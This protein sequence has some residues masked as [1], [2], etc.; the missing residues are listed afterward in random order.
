MGVGQTKKKPTGLRVP[1]RAWMENMRVSSVQP[2]DEPV[3]KGDG[4]LNPDPSYIEVSEAKPEAALD[5]AKLGLPVFPCKGK[6]PLVEYGFKAA[7]TDPETISGWWKKWPNANIGMPTG[8]VSGIVGLDVDVKN[9][10][11]GD[12]ELSKLQKQYGALPDTPQVLTP[13]GGM[14]F[15]FQYPGT[16]VKSTSGELGKGIDIRGDGGYLIVPP[17]TIKQQAY[18]WEASSP[19]FPSSMPDWLVSLTR[20]PE[21]IT[22]QSS[23]SSDSL[24]VEGN[25][26]AH[27]ASL[28]GSM[29]RRDMSADAI[30]NALLV[31][32][33]RCVPP[34]SET[35]VKRIASSVARYTPEQ[36]SS[37][38]LSA[39]TFSPVSD[40][41]VTPEPLS[42]LI[43]EY[44]TPGC[45]GLIFGDP[46]AGKSL[47]ALDW[48]ASIAT[49]KDWL[50]GTV[51]PGP[52]IYIAGEGHFGIKRRLKA[53]A[54]K[55][56]LESELAE[57]QLFLSDTGAAFL[58]ASSFV[59]VLDAITQLASQYGD[60]SAII[61]DTLHRNLGP[62]D[63]NSAS[64]IATFINAADRLR[65]FFG[66]SVVIVHHSGH[67]G[68]DRS[69]GSS[70]I[71]A[72]MD[73]EFQLEVRAGGERVLTCQKMKDGPTPQ[74]RAFELEEIELPWP[75]EAG[76]LETSVVLST[77]NLTTACKARK[78]PGSIKL[79]V[80]TL[81]E[82]IRAK[83]VLPPESKRPWEVPP[84]DRV[85]HLSDWREAFYEKHTG[86]NH[87]TKRQAFRRVRSDMQKSQVIFVINDFYWLTPERC[88]QWPELAGMLIATDLSRPVVEP[89]K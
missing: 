80:E 49:G 10:L 5:Y 77:T 9:G 8:E 43:P 15:W 46:A 88:Q 70:S 58:D 71:R 75:T 50:T 59:Q 2:V 57:A 63:E 72:A 69:R 14:H 31:E 34:L 68:K 65:E 64:D 6:R 55:H 87:A 81:L 52:V 24:Y 21:P 25:R 41:L 11:D 54:I 3:S 48:A 7:T 32:N 23:P 26:N 27:L 28:A 60:P 37:L 29:R 56:G 12:E 30:K 85:A 78:M 36:E 20:K 4:C 13:S 22:T 1:R 82:A 83:G 74:Q 84:P 47:L 62:G 40:L 18:E 67:T 16:P 17:S 38:T 61:I 51:K 53:W 45:L 42:Y 76:D 19:D 35:E 66:S 33:K 39:F 86:D 89:W 79:G 73:A 44:L